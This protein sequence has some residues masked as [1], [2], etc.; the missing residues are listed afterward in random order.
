MSDFIYGI[1]EVKF[2]DTT[3]GYIEKSS[4]DW[5]GAKPESTD[6]EA[7]QAPGAPVLIIPTKNATIAPTFNMIQLNYKS[8]QT[9]LG[10]TLV[11]GDTN[12]TG[13]K[14]PTALVSLSGKFTIK[15]VS[16]QICTI[17]SALML[18]NLGGKL[19]LT[20]VSKL[21]CQLKLMMPTDG[22]APYEINDAS[23]TTSTSSSK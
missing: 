13:W 18:S 2:D 3:L 5:G 4:W 16:G 11:G 1:G 8:F 20:E 22:S 9:V 23:T 7:E 10:G 15:F 21:E 17:P 12:P 6:V 14:A 19:T